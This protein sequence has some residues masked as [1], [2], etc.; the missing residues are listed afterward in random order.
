M[1]LITNWLRLGDHFG[2]KMLDFKGD[3]GAHVLEKLQ[4]EKVVW[5]TTVAHSGT[6]EPNPVWFYW[7]GTEI[8]VYSQPASFKLRNIPIHPRVSL[9]FEGGGDD[10]VILTGDAA[11]EPHA[12]VLNNGYARKYLQD[13]TDLGM[14]L[15][16]FH[17]DYSVA[18][19]ITPTNY[20][21]F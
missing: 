4:T 5:L 10:V 6:P 3:F 18:I 7:E 16:Q 15:D 20:R 11:I 2:G 17:A 21:G 14:T 9:N 1:E 12:P 8:L 13:I 19:H